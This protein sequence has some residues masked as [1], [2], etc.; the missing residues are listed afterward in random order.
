MALQSFVDVT[1]D[2]HFPL[3]NLPFGVFKP[4]HGE[5]RVGVALGKLV[6]DLSVLEEK[7]HFDSPEF[8][9]GPVFA[10]PA[11]N[12]FL[13]L[14]RPA[15]RKTRETLQHLLSAQTS[16]LRDDAELCGRAFH[17]QNE[18]TMQVP[19]RIGN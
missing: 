10:E 15:W 14:G 17:E 9:G 11:L 1:S 16:T 19:A 4:R 6:V 8:G 3:E 5:A 12:R 18:V 7:G 2:S 13:A